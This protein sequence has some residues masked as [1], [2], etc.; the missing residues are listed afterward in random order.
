M[1]AMVQEWTDGRLDDLSSKVDRGFVQ[2]DQRFDRVETEVQGLR[3]EMRNE[4]AAVR[5]EINGVRVE[6]NGVRVEINGVRG[7]INGVRGEMGKM[8]LRIDDVQRAIAYGAIAMTGA[9]LAG[10]AAICTLIATQL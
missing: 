3:L 2:V 5:G 6:I 7:E 1:E 9:I 4:F 8:V 10:F